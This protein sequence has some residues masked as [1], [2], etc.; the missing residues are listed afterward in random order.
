MATSIAPWRMPSSTLS[1]CA[2]YL[3]ASFP[4]PLDAPFTTVQAQAAGIGPR[5]LTQLVADGYLRRPMKGAYV[6][7]QVPDSRELRGRVLSLLAPPASVVCDWT[8]TWYWTGVDHPGSRVGTSELSVFRFRGHERLRNG[9]VRSG[10]RWFKPSDVVPLSGHVS[11]ATP[12]RTALDL[13]RFFPRL[14]AIGG[15]DALAGT[16]TFTVAELSAEVSRFNRQRG[17][18]QLRHLAPLVDPRAESTGESALR[19]RWRE[20]PGLPA[21]RSQIS[22]NTQAGRELYRLDLGVEEILFAAEYDGEEWHS[23]PEQQRHDRSRRA[24]L[25]DEFGWHIEVFR[26][27][28]VFGQHE[29]VTSRL[30]KAIAQARRTAA[31]RVQDVTTR[32]GSWRRT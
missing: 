17:V 10:E 18:V 15:M 32:A 8:A 24:T 28:D 1:S 13:G 25:R 26:R 20:E 3:S 4:L 2:T 27:E 7:S 14:V 30:P 23:S 22:V 16:G 6:A 21:P 12:L 31:K 5:R 29:T 9:L 19:L 11:V